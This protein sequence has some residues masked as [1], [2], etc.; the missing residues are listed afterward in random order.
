MNDKYTVAATL[1]EM[2]AGLLVNEPNYDLLE[3]QAM[4]MVTLL[5]HLAK[6]N[7]SISD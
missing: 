6:I 2:Q 7:E 3:D 5:R 4:A 1:S